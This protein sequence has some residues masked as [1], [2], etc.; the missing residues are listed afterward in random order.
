VRL[1]FDQ[2]LS[3]RLVARLADLFPESVHVR[4]VG[5]ERGDDQAVWDYAAAHGLVIVSKDSDFH[6]RSFLLGPPPKVIWVR[7]ANC[8]TAEIERLL[9]TRFPEIRSFLEDRDAAFLALS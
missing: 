2:N 5:L 4:H 7:L 1:L 6:Q 8:S 9:R 3:F